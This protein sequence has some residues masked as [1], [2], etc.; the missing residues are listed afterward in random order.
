MASLTKDQV[1]KLAPEQQEAF[2]SM[3]TTHARWRQDLLKQCRQPWFYRITAGILLVAV[4]ASALFQGGEARW[5]S[6]ATV[7]LAFA[8]QLHAAVLHRRLDALLALLSADSP[9]ASAPD[10]PARSTV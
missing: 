5:L 2:A 6:G 8:V 10:A 3:L 4:I 7:I 1:Q 9:S